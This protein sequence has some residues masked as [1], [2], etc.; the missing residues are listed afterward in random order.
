[1][2]RYNLLVTHGLVGV[3]PKD[4]SKVYYQS[5]EGLTGKVAEVKKPEFM[6]I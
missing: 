6:I 4:Y 1:M 5:G 2:N 3:E